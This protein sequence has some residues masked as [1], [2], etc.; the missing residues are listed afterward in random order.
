MEPDVKGAIAGG[1]FQSP[2]DPATDGKTLIDW[3]LAIRSSQMDVSTL[4][5]QM[6]P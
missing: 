2:H 3:G 4:V 6:E 1:W 5:I